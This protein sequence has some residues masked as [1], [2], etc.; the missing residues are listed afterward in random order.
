VPQNLKGS[1][2]AEEEYGGLGL[3]GGGPHGVRNLDNDESDNGG[4]GQNDSSGK[5]HRLLWHQGR[6]TDHKQGHGDLGGE[7]RDFQHH[8]IIV[9]AVHKP[10]GQQLWP[11]NQLR[12]HQPP[13]IAELH[14]DHIGAS[15]RLTM[16]E[17]L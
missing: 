12:R 14:G 9:G 3:A 6:T 17:R 1:D 13:V 8:W 10:V 16:D 2:D 4:L 7:P 5:D 15:I 11:G